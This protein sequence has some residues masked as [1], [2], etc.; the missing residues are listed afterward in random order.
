MK[1]R[2]SRA[3]LVILTAMMAINSPCLAADATSAPQQTAITLDEA[4]RLTREHNPRSLQAAEEVRAA[5]ATVTE[6]RSGFF[7]QLSAKAGYTYIDP[8][9]ELPL[10]GTMMKFM[11]N[12][13]YDA[14]ITAE[15]MLFDFGRTGR[16][17]DIAKSG[18]EAA[19]IRRDLT[20][21]DLSLATVRAFYSVMFL[22]EAVRVQDKE[23][24]A[25][26]RNLDHMQKRYQQGAATRY[27]LLT[28]QVRLAAAGNRKIDLQTQLENQ[29]IS[30]RRLCGLKG[31][32]PLALQGS[33][34]IA[35]TDTDM[36]KLTDTALD[37][38]PEVMLSR[39]NA[40]AASYRKSLAAK[41]GMPKIVGAASWGSTNGYQP[42]I[43]EMRSNIMAGVQLQI[44]IFSGFRTKASTSGAKAMMLAAEQ[45]RID[46]EELAQAEV[47]Q[48]IN[49][50]RTSRE[51]IDTTALQVSQADLAAQHAR[52]RYQNGLGTTLDL[53][54]A[55]AALAQAELGN[56]QA[57]Y[58]YVLDAYN[59]RRAAGD[60]IAH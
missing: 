4:L 27:D 13:N 19:G 25:L 32:A 54:D 49:S 60:L 6:S 59:V 55:E 5:E 9:S 51:K 26:Q 42:D 11:P 50:L 37:H 7:P 21:R 14:K 47:K 2:N 45:A 15:M 29:E 20:V 44:P 24:A 56:L 28:T 48:S 41:E 39:E 33:F 34:D 1:K 30:L 53:L 17:V 18:K 31:D 46:T 22:Q 43:N 8:V 40:R 3:A 23:I 36:K 57:R 12:D 58:E 35:T 52:L 38:R 10:G 16:Q